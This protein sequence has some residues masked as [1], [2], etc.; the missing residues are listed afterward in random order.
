MS[1]INVFLVD[2]HTVLRQ[3]LRLLIE[4]QPDMIVVGESDSGRGVAE[5]LLATGADVIVLDVSMPDQSG[6]KAAVDIRRVAPEVRILALTRH[7]ERAYLQQMFNAGAAGYV[8][9]QTAAE[10]L[11]TAIRAVAQGGRYVDPAMAEKETPV[12][13]RM[14]SRSSETSL[15][16]RE[17]QIV[18]LIAYGH[19]NKEIASTLEITVK[20][21][22]THKSNIMQRLGLGSRSDLV[23]FALDQ[24]WLRQ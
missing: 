23:R 14:P 12:T 13:A 11:I 10:L 18:T 17:Q 22:E 1:T 2:D 7:T 9:K 21:V 8:L 3:G 4:A 24:G 20:T 15:T 16:P 19:T 5:V 6:A